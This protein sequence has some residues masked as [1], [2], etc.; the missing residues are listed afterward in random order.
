MP[1]A[2]IT[3]PGSLSI[4]NRQKLPSPWNITE[5]PAIRFDTMSYLAGVTTN[6]PPVTGEDAE[7][8]KGKY[9]YNGPSQALRRLATA[10]GAQGAILPIVP[11]S[12]NASWTSQ[13]DA[14]ALHCHTLS[15][16]EQSDVQ[17]DIGEHIRKNCEDSHAYLFGMTACLTTQQ[18]ILGSAVV[19]D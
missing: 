5:V 4:T 11:P 7:W 2:S 8:L 15:E 3:T 10:I 12:P 14:P 16:S 18:A 9:S 6:P 13:L 1:L 17:S 19:L